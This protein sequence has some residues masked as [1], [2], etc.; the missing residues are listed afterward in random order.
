MTAPA[1]GYKWADAEPGNTLAAKSGAWSPRLVGAAMNELRPQ[2]EAV[3]AE[4]P[5]CKPVDE[6]ALVDFLRDM[7]R[8]EQLERWLA[9]NGDRYPE[10]HKRAGELRDYDL[11]HLGALRNRLL[12]HRARL[13]LDPASRARAGFERQS[14]PDLASIWAES[15]ELE[16]AELQ[17]GER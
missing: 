14:G 5:W 8:A 6:L 15:E 7:A 4:A 10:G 17:E 12:T 13:G 2:L 3:I 11:R 16:V 1:R 9:E